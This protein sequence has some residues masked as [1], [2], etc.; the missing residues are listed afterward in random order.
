M[1]VTKFVFNLKFTYINYVL[2]IHVRTAYNIK[3]HNDSNYVS[4]FLY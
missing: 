1:E 4:F 3:T 2:T